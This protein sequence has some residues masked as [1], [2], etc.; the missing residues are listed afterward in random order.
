MN[1]GT[2]AMSR[3]RICIASTTTNSDSNMRFRFA[4]EF[5]L[6]ARLPASAMLLRAV[7][8]DFFE[9]ERIG[10]MQACVIRYRHLWRAPSHEAG[11]DLSDR[12]RVRMMA[13]FEF[14]IGWRSEQRAFAALIQHVSDWRAVASSAQARQFAWCRTASTSSM[15]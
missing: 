13:S 5:T 1:S 10:T 11:F 4:W 2:R 12:A 3:N 14:G 8:R 15:D 9:A 6:W 7:W